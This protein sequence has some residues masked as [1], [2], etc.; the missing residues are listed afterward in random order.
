MQ[1]ADYVKSIE[2]IREAFHNLVEP[3]GPV[4]RPVARKVVEDALEELEDYRYKRREPGGRWIC[5]KDH[6]WSEAKGLFAV[7]PDAVTFGDGCAEGCCDD[8]RCPH[9]GHEWRVEY[10]Q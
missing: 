5:K 2:K 1:E 8:F 4:A 3:T 7:H 9:C 6:P 10:P